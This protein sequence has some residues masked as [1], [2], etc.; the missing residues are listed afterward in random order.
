MRRN[1]IG[2]ILGACLAM[3]LVA[4]GSSSGP[5]ASS[6]HEAATAG[7]TLV[8]KSASQVVSISM[9]AA[10]AKGSVHLVSTDTGAGG[11]GESTYDIGRNEGKQTV[12]GA[13]TGTS[14]LVLVSGVAYV[15]GDATFLEN[16]FGFPASAAA[17]YAGTWISFQ[18]TDTGY[19]QIVDGDTLVSALADSTPNGALA[20]KGT[21]VIDHKT[22]LAVSGGL[23]PDVSGT[24][25]TGSVVLY[26]STTAPFLPVELVEQATL[27][28]K[29]GTTTVLFSNWGEDVLALAPTNA[30]PI[31]ALTAS[32]A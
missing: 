16:A 13:A 3:G 17:T 12:S 11:P 24:G 8:G 26:V 32:P 23:P 31:S 30:T 5:G 20:L 22:V 29:S 2:P 25:V 7:I 10:T 18:S 19:E 1:W 28:G 15:Q 14:S 27:S 4:C 9:A 6:A 21:S